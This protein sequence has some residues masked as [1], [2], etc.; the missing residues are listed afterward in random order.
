MD[1][2]QLSWIRLR[3]RLKKMASEEHSGMDELL[4]IEEILDLMDEI[5]GG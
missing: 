2:F 3:K 4:S 1:E 5:E